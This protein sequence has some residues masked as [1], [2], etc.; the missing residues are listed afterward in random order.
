MVEAAKR[1]GKLLQIAYHERFM[2]N[3]VKAKEIIDS[4]ELGKIYF[5]KTSFCRWRGRPH[6]DMPRFA[7]WFMKKEK[8]GGGC[9]MDI[10][11]YHLDLVLGLLGFPEPKSVDCVTYQEIDR[12]RAEKEGVDVEELGIGMVKFKNGMTLLM[13]SAFAVNVDM[14]QPNVFF[15]G[16]EAGLKI[17][18]LTVFRDE[19][20]KPKEETIQV[21]APP[22]GGIRVLPVMQFVN[23]VV[24]GKQIETCSGDEELIVLRIQELLY[25]SAE[26]GREIEFTMP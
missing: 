17:R 1:A 4:G 25:R 24:E 23:A 8:A 21:P 3:A 7:S 13:E 20:G 18:P 16:S 2:P 12:E 10:G 6:F 26:E 22:E 15:F 14:G 5:V 19:D 9:I 11:G